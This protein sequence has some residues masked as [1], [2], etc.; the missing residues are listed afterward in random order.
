MGRFDDIIEKNTRRYSEDGEEET[1]PQGPPINLMEL[2]EA[3]DSP[4]GS[5]LENVNPEMKSKILVPLM[6][7]LDKYGLGDSLGK[8]QT[9]TSAV[10]L[11]SVLGDIAPVVKGISEFV[12]G[13]RNSLADEDKQFLQDIMA[14]DNSSEF[15]DLFTDIGESEASA[16]VN[17]A[18]N[19]I[20]HPLL[21]EIPQVNPHEGPVDWMSVLDPDGKFGS[22][23]RQR[24]EQVD[25]YAELMPKAIF[26]DAPKIK[27]PSLED[28]AAEAGLSM[29]ELK[30]KDSNIRPDEDKV[31]DAILDVSSDFFDTSIMESIVDSESVD[32]VFYLSD[33][34]VAELEAQGYSFDEV[35]EEDEEWE[36]EE[37]DN[38]ED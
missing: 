32:E 18:S 17:T 33:D 12:T 26:D 2:L 38:S 34:E 7:L 9:A 13:Q 31:E 37:E 6:G 10:G 24:K 36:D 5:L 29:N 28:L 22:E 30:A 16:P 3:E 14:A 23:D 4:F 20:N 21:G 27:M 11:M 1:S 15:S 35:E 19:T 8:S 25:A